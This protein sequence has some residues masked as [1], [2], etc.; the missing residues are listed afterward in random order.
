VHLFEGRW[1][2]TRRHG[3]TAIRGE[4]LPHI[5]QY[6]I[7]EQEVLQVQELT[8]AIAE[9]ETKES[10]KGKGKEWAKTPEESSDTSSDKE[11]E[12]PINQQIRNSP[13]NL[14]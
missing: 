12:S 9:L 7:P 3:R 10:A 8:A 11:T 13:I 5:H 6:N 1:H 2:Q 14:H 4:Y